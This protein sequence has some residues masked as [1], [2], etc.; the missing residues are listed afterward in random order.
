MEDITLEEENPFASEY[1]VKC[2]LLGDHGCG[3][4]TMTHLY[5]LEE[6]PEKSMATIGIEFGS[7]KI[8]IP[9]HDQTVK[10]QIWDTAGSER[11]KS[12]IKSYMRNVDIAFFVF[13]VSRRYTF[14]DLD[15]WKKELIKTQQYKHIPIVALVGC[16]MDLI[17][18]QVTMKEMQKKAKEFKAKLFTIS[19]F[20]DNSY[21]MIN[22]MF[23]ETAKKYHET[24]LKNYKAGWAIPEHVFDKDIEEEQIN[25][26]KNNFCCYQ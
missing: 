8:H 23:Y 14:E 2:I 26:M 21:S 22:R 6:L 3:K 18:K 11:F 12:I 19:C 16:K 5:E 10:V 15:M 24:I 7:K 20:Q 25:L 4:T 9:D 17:D 1:V 13:D